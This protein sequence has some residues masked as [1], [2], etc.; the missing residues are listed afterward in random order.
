MSDRDLRSRLRARSGDVDSDARWLLERVR[1]G[2]VT[3]AEVKLEAWAGDAAAQRVAEGFADR[4][5][6]DCAWERIEEWL[7]AH[8]PTLAT[9]LRGG[10]DASALDVLEWQVG[11]RLPE[12]VARSWRRHDG[13]EERSDGVLGGWRLLSAEEAWQRWRGLKSMYRGLQALFGDELV[14]SDSERV[15]PVLWSASRIPWAVREVDLWCVDLAPAPSGRVGQV[16]E[17]RHDGS[18]A[19]VAW[20]VPDL[21]AQFACDLHGGTYRA[22]SGRLR[23]R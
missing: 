16:I 22:E 5:L 21:L 2:A 7:E 9:Q 17:C 18:V 12:A 20:S 10:A 23:R 4:A 13:E 8:A 19:W 3:P 14:A 6:D 15:E 1:A 11:A